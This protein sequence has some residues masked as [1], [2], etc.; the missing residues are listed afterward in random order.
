MP[1]PHHDVRLIARKGRPYL[2]TDV[3]AGGPAAR[4][5]IQ[6]G[7]LITRLDGATPRFDELSQARALLRSRPAGTS[8][9]IELK[10]RTDVKHVTLVLEDQI[11]GRRRADELGR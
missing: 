11:R 2:V 6:A 5:G 8:V 1:R 4:A 10:R 3:S 9:E 7:D